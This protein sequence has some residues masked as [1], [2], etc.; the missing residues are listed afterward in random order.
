MR[1]I[2]KP[3]I[4]SGIAVLLLVGLYVSAYY[5]VIS[6]AYV[7]QV[8]V[9]TKGASHI[10]RKSE[11]VY[12]LPWPIPAHFNQPWLLQKLKLW[13]GPAHQLDRLLRR[14][15]WKDD[16]PQP[17]PASPPVNWMDQFDRPSFDP[18]KLPLP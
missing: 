3:A 14:D 4:V 17:L 12:S 11:P 6:R 10:Q 2:R 9:N 16:P 1:R 13:F 15:V 8:M 18:G 7:V 5:R